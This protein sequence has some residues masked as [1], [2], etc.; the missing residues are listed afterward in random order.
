MFVSECI[1]EICGDSKEDFFKKP[2]FK[3]IYSVIDT[4]Y[5]DRYGK[6]EAREGDVRAER[7]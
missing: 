5:L 7:A 1:V 2:W 4:W 3:E 6:R